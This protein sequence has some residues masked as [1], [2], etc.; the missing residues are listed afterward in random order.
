MAI[1]RSIAY[2]LIKHLALG[3]ICRSIRNDHDLNLDMF[4]F[5]DEN[6]AI[7]LDSQ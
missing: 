4:L 7:Q 1:R 6:I 5:K 2:Y 3:Q